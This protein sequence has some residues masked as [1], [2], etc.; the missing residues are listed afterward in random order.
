MLMPLIYPHACNNLVLSSQPCSSNPLVILV[1]F[2]CLQ[3]NHSSCAVNT[4]LETCSKGF[5]PAEEE[6]VN[7][8]CVF[9]IAYILWKG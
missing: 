4:V 6:D 9:D 8:T 5:I 2:L 1:V 3:I 7:P